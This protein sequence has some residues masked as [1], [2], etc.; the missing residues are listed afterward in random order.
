MSRPD[1]SH[2]IE[3]PSVY[4]G[5]EIRMVTVRRPN[6]DIT[7][8]AVGYLHRI[9]TLKGQRLGWDAYVFTACG[10]YRNRERPA[11]KVEHRFAS[12][13][14]AADC[15]WD[16]RV[17]FPD[18]GRKSAMPERPRPGTASTRKAPALSS[19]RGWG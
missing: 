19:L 15:V 18:T 2:R 6:S 13:I 7:G 1:K 14:E 11:E 9:D 5:K 16:N 8:E 10:S 3:L 4:Y 17:V 12:F